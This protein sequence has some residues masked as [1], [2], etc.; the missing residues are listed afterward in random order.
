MTY[1]DQ[2][3]VFAI[4]QAVNFDHLPSHRWKA[5]VVNGQ[6]VLA[7]CGLQHSIRT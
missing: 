2:V 4:D 1:V 6:H 3:L 5:K 7:F